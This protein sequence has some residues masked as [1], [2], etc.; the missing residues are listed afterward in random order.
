MKIN[1]YVEDLRKKSAAELSDDSG[2]LMPLLS[3]AAALKEAEHEQRKSK[4][5]ISSDSLFEVQRNG[6]RYSLKI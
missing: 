3:G 2:V 1:K 6:S 4:D 5:R